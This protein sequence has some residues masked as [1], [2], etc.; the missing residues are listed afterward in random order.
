[1]QNCP[2]AGMWS[3]SVWD[4]ES[5]TAAAVALATCGEDGVAA[6]YSLDPQTGA[7]SRWFAANLGVSDLT[8]LDDMQGVLALGGSGAAAAGGDTLAAAEAS[9]Q[10]HDCPSAGMWSIAVWDG[11][12]D[13]TTADALATC[14]EGSV[15]AAY[16]LSATGAWSRWFAANPGVSDL[17]SLDDMQGVLA[18]GSSGFSL[19]VDK[20]GEG[21]V[22]S[23]PG[24]IDCGA[25]CT[26][27]AATFSPNSSVI[28]TAAATPGS[29]FSHWT[30]CDSV[31]DN[32]CTA[33][34]DGDK[35]VFATFAL[36][37]LRLREG[38]KVLDEDTMGHLLRQ[39]GSIY[40]FDQGAEVA[41]QLQPGDVILSFAGGGLLRRVAQVS[42]SGD[43]IAVDTIGAS[44]EEAIERG[45][46]GLSADLTSTSGGTSELSLAGI[47]LER[48]CREPQPKTLVP[49]LGLRGEIQSGEV[50]AELEVSGSASAMVDA[51]VR[52]EP[53]KQEVRFVGTLKPSVNVALSMSGAIDVADGEWSLPPIPPV[54]FGVVCLSGDVKLALELKAKAG[55]EVE[56]QWDPTVQLGF[57]ALRSGGSLNINGIGDLSAEF[58]PSFSPTLHLEAKLWLKFALAAKLFNSAG[59]EYGAGPYV[60]LDIAPLEVPWGRAFVGILQGEIKGVLDI[61]FLDVI[62]VDVR[63]ATGIGEW[64]VWRSLTPEPTPIPT[65]ASSATPTPTPTPP[66]DLAELI[67]QEKARQEALGW[68]LDCPD[69]TPKTREIIGTFD[70]LNDHWIAMFCES[71]S[72]EPLTDKLVIYERQASSLVAL[73]DFLGS[74]IGDLSMGPLADVQGDALNDLPVR[75]WIG[76]NDIA[77]VKLRIYTVQDHEVTEIPVDLPVTGILGPN[78]FGDGTSAVPERLA[79]LNGDGSQEIVAND[80]Q[81]VLHGFAHFNSPYANYVLEWD[82]QRYVNASR[83]AQFQAYFDDT[84]AWYEEDLADRTTDDYR[85]SRAI[86][87]LL[88]YG[89]SGRASQGWAR[90]HEIAAELTT[91]CWKDALPA[92]EEELELSVPKDGSEPS[93]STAQSPLPVC[94]NV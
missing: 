80:V 84:I 24:G 54:C 8:S 87:I 92:F 79:D 93:T 94:P 76:C 25:G 63:P 2:P 60:R 65:P 14:G 70:H 55:G 71:G 9:G 27:Q 68:T 23:S 48:G 36:T 15:V 45:T 75:D 62:D 26:Y 11:A 53:G 28:L 37:E 30:G 73:F 66:P 81:W 47:K 49:T 64:E 12:D 90:F 21:T 32:S 50:E 39:E 42:I 52:I 10:I 19:A 31:S 22:T 51:C 44:L 7:W 59:L 35:T 13:A 82:G 38:T 4:G 1:M 5:G 69:S 41:A 6:A 33:T 17:T 86:S 16:S 3:I 61:L 58:Q 18:L 46:L 77:C 67:A 83:E 20:F 72:T 56:F 40:Y 88:L 29:V 43:Q 34:I 74:P 91:Q 57:H 85:L 78:H 89:H